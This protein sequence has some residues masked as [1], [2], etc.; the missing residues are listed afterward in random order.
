MKVTVDIKF[1]MEDSTTI[2]KSME[3][4]GVDT[5]EALEKYVSDGISVGFQGML[6]DTPDEIKVDE[7]DVKVK[8]EE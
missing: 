8:I 7:F 6:N 5:V 4:L 2:Q 3:D 1:S